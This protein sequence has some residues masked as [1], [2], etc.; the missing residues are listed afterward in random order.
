MRE[1]TK[2]I[3]FTIF[4]LIPIILASLAYFLWV[5]E[6]IGFLFSVGCLFSWSWAI[7]AYLLIMV[8]IVVIYDNSWLGDF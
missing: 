6:S 8:F 1:K 5:Y 3:L 4:I 7:S 2:R